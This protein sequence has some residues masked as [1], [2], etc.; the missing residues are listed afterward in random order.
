MESSGRQAVVGA[1]VTNLG[2]ST[3]FVWRE[4]GLFAIDPVDGEILYAYAYAGNYAEN[5]PAYSTSPTSF[6][7]SFNITFE[8][9]SSVE[10]VA[11]TSLAITTHEELEAGLATRASRNVY[12]VTLPATDWT[13]QASGLYA[14]TV[15][16]PGIVATDSCGN[17]G[18]V[19]TGDETV[20]KEVRKSWNR[21]IRMEAAADSVVAY[22][23]KAPTVAIP[24]RMEIFR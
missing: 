21:I 2:I 5:I 16:L 15:P 12:D 7:F 10:V 17:V 18:P 1:L 24:I 14:V 9:T 20:D 11:D 23:S 8:N 19:Q 3:S 6:Y 22:A 4:I 13:Q